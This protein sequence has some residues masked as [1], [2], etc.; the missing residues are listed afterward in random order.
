MCPDHLQRPY[1]VTIIG[2]DDWLAMGLQSTLTSIHAPS[3]ELV[4]RDFALCKLGVW[5][6][7][8]DP[9]AVVYLNFKNI[10]LLF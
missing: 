10:F 6:P 9:D 8:R 2:F 5:G 4:C 3:F 1:C 7:L